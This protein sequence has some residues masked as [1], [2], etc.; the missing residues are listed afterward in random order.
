MPVLTPRCLRQGAFYQRRVLRLGGS[1]QRRAIHQ[2]VPACHLKLTTIATHFMG[3]R[4]PW[5]IFSRRAPTTP[6]FGRPFVYQGQRRREQLIPVLGLLSQRAMTLLLCCRRVRKWRCRFQHR[7][8]CQRVTTRKNVITMTT[9][10]PMSR[11]AACV[12]RGRHVRRET[13]GLGMDS[14]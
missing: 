14:N 9:P 12:S 7:E 1:Y 11:S 13:C 10:K 6:R 2:V 4:Y 8:L 3:W 5:P